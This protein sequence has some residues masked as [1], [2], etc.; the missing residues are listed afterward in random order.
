MRKIHKMPQYLK[1]KQLYVLCLELFSDKILQFCKNI[2]RSSVWAKYEALM[3]AKK[4]LAENLSN[5]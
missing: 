1:V 2:H 3:S 4:Y 5:W